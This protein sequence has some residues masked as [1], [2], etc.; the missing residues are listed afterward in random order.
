M[1]A[2]I[3]SGHGSVGMQT[4]KPNHENSCKNGRKP[5]WKKR[6]F[7]QADKKT[8]GEPGRGQ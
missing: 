3:V 1:E 4:R 8:S 6:Y 2:P 7:E 5:L